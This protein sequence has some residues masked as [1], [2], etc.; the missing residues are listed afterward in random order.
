MPNMYP[1]TVNFLFSDYDYC[2]KQLWFQGKLK[3]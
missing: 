3:V 2:G 1:D